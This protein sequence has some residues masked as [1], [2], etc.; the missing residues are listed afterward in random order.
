MKPIRNT[1]GWISLLIIVSIIGLVLH[2]AGHA[3]TAVL[4]G[5][6]IIDIKFLNLQVWP[7]VR[8]IPW[9]GLMGGIRYSGIDRN[10]L[11]TL[12]G[13]GLTALLGLSASVALL[14]LRSRGCLWRVCLSAAALL[15]LDIRA[16]SVFPAL[17]LRHWI[18]FGGSTVEPLEGAMEMG[19]TQTA[20]YAA[21]A[22]YA[23]V[24]YGSLF[25][26][27]RRPDRKKAGPV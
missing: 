27:L 11:V 25:L 16:Y 19:A 10:G 21:S 13:S 14:A 18:L 12:M 8:W 20:Y 26:G 6:D 5:G 3:L 15:P 7:A 23:L 1:A 17:G 2:E 9:D 22:V 4:C 24:C